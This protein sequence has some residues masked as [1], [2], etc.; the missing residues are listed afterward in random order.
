M[1]TISPGVGFQILNGGKEE[2]GKTREGGLR[3]DGFIRPAKKEPRSFPERVL[4]AILERPAAVDGGP[5][6]TIMPRGGRSA[7]D[8]TLVQAPLRFAL[9]L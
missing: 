2:R 4:L 9:L 1:R 8:R 6:K 7:R 5:G 3:G